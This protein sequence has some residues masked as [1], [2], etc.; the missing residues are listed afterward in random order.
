MKLVYFLLVLAFL[1]AIILY[2]V[3]HSVPVME[4][5]RRARQGDKK[6]ANLYKPAAYEATFDLIIWLAA[7]A[8]GAVL[9]IWSA[10]TSWWL[11][12]LVIVVGAWMMVWGKFPAGGWAGSLMALFG[13]VHA[14]FLSVV[15]PVLGRIAAVMPAGLSVAS[16]TGVYEKKDLLEFLTRQNRQIDNRIPASD[17]QIARNAMSF[18]DM[19][20]GSVMTPRREIRFVQA[21]DPIGPILVDELHKTGFTRFPVVKDSAKAAS[22]QVVGTL[23][24]NNLIGYDGSGKIKDL[25]KHEVYFINEDA[26]LR[27]ALNAFLSTHHHLLIVVNSFEETVGVISLEDVLEQIIGKQIMDEF[28]SYQNLRAVASMKAQKEQDQHQEVKPEQ[29]PQTVVE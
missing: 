16:H 27:Q 7:V 15:Q 12:A 24:L 25:M 21:N 8:S 4:L 20:V 26:T 2:K 5:K 9:L 1:K 3:Y 14:K 18:G 29:T 17:L 23:Y 13:P 19:A 22:P 11:A 6:A 10:R 28:D